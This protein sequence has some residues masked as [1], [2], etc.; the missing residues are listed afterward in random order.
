MHHIVQ[1]VEQRD[2]V[3][4]FE[5]TIRC[6]FFVLRQQQFVTFGALLRASPFLCILR[7]EWILHCASNLVFLD[8]DELV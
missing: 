8:V 2:D 4:S 7:R 1:L 5:S 3:E 6:K